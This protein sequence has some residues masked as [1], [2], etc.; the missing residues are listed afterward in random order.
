MSLPIV[1][2]FIPAYESW[3]TRNPT[4]EEH[5]ASYKE[6]GAM[7]PPIRDKLLATVD[8]HLSAAKYMAKQGADNQLEKH[9]DDTLANSS[10]YKLWRDEMPSKTPASISKFQQNYPSYKQ[11]DVDKEIN[12]INQT[13]SEGQFLFHG[14]LWFDDNKDEIIL[15]KPFSTSFCPQVALRNSEHLGKAYDDGKIDL[16][17][18]KVKKPQTNIFAFKLNGTSMGHE[19]EVLFASGAKLKF[20]KRNLIRQDYNVGKPNFANKKIPIYVIEV[21]I[22]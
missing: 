4:I 22:S 6:N 8:N 16:F 10:A 2:T 19:K 11:A 5:E 15:E 12:E 13:L 21:D 17:V 1:N 7:S 20:Q 3:S 9:I 18:L 14:G